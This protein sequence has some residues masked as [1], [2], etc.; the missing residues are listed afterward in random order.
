MKFKFNTYLASLTGVVGVFIPTIVGAGLVPCGSRG[1]APCTMC[2][3]IVLGQE[4]VNYGLG[5][6]ATVA[7]VVI[8]IAGIMYIVSTG[9]ESTI[10]T[11][12][13]AM[14]YS[15]IGALVVLL[16]WV[17]INTL[18]WRFLP[19]SGFQVT[20]SWS[21]YQCGATVNPT[22]Q[23][24]DVTGSGRVTSPDSPGSGRV[25]SPDTTPSTQPGYCFT[26]T[27]PTGRTTQCFDSEA[28]CLSERSRVVTNN[29][30]NA[31]NQQIIQT[32][33]ILGIAPPS[34]VSTSD[35][36]SVPGGRTI[37]Q[38]Y[39][40]FCYRVAGI[41]SNGAQIDTR[42]CYNSM[43]DC[44]TAMEGVLATNVGGGTGVAITEFCRGEF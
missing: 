40:R 7:I 44:I 27:I 38:V 20:G 28:Q 30:I 2:D 22:G 32:A 35:C 18:I 1:Q 10:S 19:T 33:E 34:L 11:A 25:T 23:G 4:I 3:F 21:S 17:L 41:Q 24:G 12:K 29:Q 8:T 37:T 13:A 36:T 9:N 31:L 5:I 15:I 26:S 16:A 14:K 42:P 6:V 43:N 39:S